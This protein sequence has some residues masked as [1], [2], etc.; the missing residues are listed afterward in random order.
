MKKV[1]TTAIISLGLVGTMYG[2]EAAQRDEEKIAREARE[3]A[4]NN[5]VDRLRNSGKDNIIR[6]RYRDDRI[7]LEKIKPLYRELNDDEEALLSPDP[8]FL[9]KYSGLTK[10]NDWGIVKLMMDR[11]CWR[12]PIIVESSERCE[13][14][15]MPGAGV[16]YSFREQKYKLKRLADISLTKKGFDTEGVMKHGILVNIGDV[17]LERLS[18]KDEKLRTLIE[19]QP[20]SDFAQAANFVGVLHQGIKGGDMTYGSILPVE[21]ESTYVLRSI[22]Y[23]GSNPNTVEDITYNE[24]DYDT[25]R[26]VIVAFRLLQIK[27][28]ESVTI[29]WKL[30]GEKKSPKLNN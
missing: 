4:F 10:E 28:D 18:L 14:F 3:S 25:R 11:G 2:Q 16:S 22:A 30:L 7:Y 23:R 27:P 12:E 21:N 17:P 26:D 15:N 13:N 5:R 1:L 24:L 29:L 8:E 6:D 9:K 20:A 19:F